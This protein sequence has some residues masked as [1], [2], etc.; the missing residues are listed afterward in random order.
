MTPLDVHFQKAPIAGTIKMVKWTK[1]KHRNALS[2]KIDINTYAENEHQEFIIE[3]DLKL[4]I[5][6]I[7]GMVARRTVSLVREMQ[8]VEKG[9]DLGLIRLGSQV[10]L[11]IPKLELKIKKGDKVF[12]GRTIIA[13]Y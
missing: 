10:T 8:Q 2:K 12:A 1:G 5:I 7:A 6:Q 4:K 11:I 13:N 3:G 9:Q